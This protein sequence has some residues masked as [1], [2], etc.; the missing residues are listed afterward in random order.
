MGTGG[1]NIK[2]VMSDIDGTILDSAHRVD[3]GL[4]ETLEQ[5]KEQKVP[6][7]L[8]S[9][10][11][12]KGMYSLAE[13]LGIRTSPLACYNG[14]LVLKEADSESHQPILSH[15]MNK[16][17][18][19]VIVDIIKDRFPE[20]T[21]NLYSGEDWYVDKYT[22]WAEIEAGITKETPIEKNVQLLM[23]SAEMPVHKLLLIGTPQEIERLQAYCQALKLESSSFYLSKENY[24]EVTHCDVSKERALLELASYY[25]V[26]LEET[27]AIGDNFNDIPMLK[28]AGLGVS[29][30][31][32]PIEVQE[33]ADIKTFS[34][35]ENGVS[36]ALQKY[37]LGTK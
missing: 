4:K 23:L 25:Q 14:A 24:L 11:S 20:I 30:A 27:M 5:L 10:R 19:G 13:E 2:L 31:N 8:A 6:F 37:V 9:A 16:T 32:A 21:I 29:M 36:K 15:E 22:R 7:I 17:E 34:N 35:N 3:D 12:P 18:V 28:L 33:A 1:S 26:D